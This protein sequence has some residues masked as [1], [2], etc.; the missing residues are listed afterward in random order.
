MDPDKR[1]V[2]GYVDYE[3]RHL[4]PLLGAYGLDL[5]GQRIVE[6]GCHI[7]ASAVVMARMGG[8]VT[9]LDIDPA[10]I[11]VAHAN[12]ALPRAWPTGR[13]RCT[14]PTPAPCLPTRPPSTSHWRTAC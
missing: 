3:E 8:T 9:G 5:A 4:A 10:A 1:W 6:L 7:G 11:S 14:C 2:G 12:L 13:A